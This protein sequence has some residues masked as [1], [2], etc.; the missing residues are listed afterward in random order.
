MLNLFILI[1]L[2][3]FDKNYINPDNPLTNFKEIEKDFQQVWAGH[4]KETLGL[5]TN[6]RNLVYF[7]LTL[8]KP[9]GFNFTHY[10]K[11]FLEKLKQ[12]PEFAQLT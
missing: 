8:K 6:E 2:E 11:K 3:Q 12:R 9:L 7:F 1:I 4:S 5:K 10:K